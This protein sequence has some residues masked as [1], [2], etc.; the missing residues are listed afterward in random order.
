M[1]N[2]YGAT[3]L[4]GGGSGALDKID[5][6]ALAAGDGAMVITPTGMLAYTLDATSGAAESSPG[7]ITPD[8]NAGTKRW[9]LVSTAIGEISAVDNAVETAIA[10]AA[11]D[12]QV[13]I[14][15]ANGIGVNTTPDHTQD[16][17]TLG[18]DGYYE[19]MV[20]AT[21]NSVGG[22]ASKAKIS[23]QKNNGS[24]IIIPPMKRNLA[25]GGGE[26]GVISMSGFANLVL[27][28]TIEVWVQNLT[29]TQNYVI[30]N[31]A[32]SMHQ[33]IEVA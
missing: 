22:G 12:Y 4:I 33:I 10:V 21:I 18:H 25:G 30:E 9:I 17:I 29:G 14:F 8:T 7:I 2:F 15:D 6:A 16:H 27:N 1:S 19:V 13:T 26:S 5:G 24:S 20:S 28:D 11:T 31:I 3:S 23:V 32:L